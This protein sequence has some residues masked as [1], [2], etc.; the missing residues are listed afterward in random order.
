M[1]RQAYRADI[2]KIM[3]LDKKTLLHDAH[4][5]GIEPTQ[6]KTDHPSL[7]ERAVSRFN[8][9]IWVA[10]IDDTLAGFIWVIESTD[11]FSGDKIGFILKLFVEEHFRNQGIATAL[12]DKAEEFCE[13]NGYQT[14]E[15]NVAQSNTVSVTMYEHRGFEIF[16][17]RMRKK[18]SGR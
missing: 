12:L 6:V 11:Y 14:L 17:Y 3:E 16:R 4:L 1:I 2:E 7:F 10:D 15:L 13:R 9:E 8:G 18:V 5:C